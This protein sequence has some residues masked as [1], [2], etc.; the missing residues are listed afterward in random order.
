MSILRM[1]P[2]DRR[3][4]VTAFP[5]EVRVRIFPTRPFI[6]KHIRPYWRIDY[7]DGSQISEILEDGSERD[8]KEIELDGIK[9]VHIIGRGYVQYLTPEYNVIVRQKKFDY[10][11]DCRDGRF[12]F[13]DEYKEF[14]CSGL[15]LNYAEGL[16]LYKEASVPIPTGN[17][18]NMPPLEPR[19][20]SL[21]FG[22]KIH[23]Q[24]KKYQVICK[25]KL[26]GEYTFS[27]SCTDLKKEAK[28]PLSFN[29]KLKVRRK[30]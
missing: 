19:I 10:F 16:I 18:A 17:L 22:Y 9:Q 11:L 12:Y 27:A 26:N 5:N 28:T 21:C 13:G 20:D 23:F 1:N 3:I 30:D 25:V 24:G 2:A 14:P 15:N 29:S 6:N 4:I 8:F 7:K